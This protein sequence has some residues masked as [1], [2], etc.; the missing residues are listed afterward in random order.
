MRLYSIKLI[1]FLLN[2]FAQ[3]FTPAQEISLQKIY[4][5]EKSD[6]NFKTDFLETDFIFS[7]GRPISL[8]VE[9]EWAVKAF[10]DPMW[11]HPRLQLPAACVFP[12]RKKVIEKIINRQLPSPACPDL[13]F[14]RQKLETTHV[15]VL[16]AGAYAQNPASVFGHSL[17]RLSNR[18][19]PKR[20]SPL[21]SYVVG[22]LA[23][24]GDDGSLARIRK[25]LLGDYPGHYLLDPFYIK[26][27]I[28]NNAESRDL[29]ESD[30]DLNPEEIDLLIDHLW[31]ISHFSKSYYFIGRNCSYQLLK[32]LEAIRPQLSLLSR[33]KIETLPHDSIRW[34]Q[35]SGLAKQETRYY[36]SLRKKINEKI[37]SLSNVN[38]KLLVDATQN[39]I[40]LDKISDTKTLEV[41]NDFWLLRNYQEKMKLTSK[42]HQLM[43]KSLIKRSQL[44]ENSSESDVFLFRES[45]PSP[46]YQGHKTHSILI[47]VNSQEMYEFS[48]F[49][50][51][52]GFEQ[53]GEGFDDFSS[54]QYLGVQTY[55][56]SYGT[57]KSETS[58]VITRI[59]SFENYSLLDNK[60]S[61]L[62]NAQIQD[63][64]PLL[65]SRSSRIV[66]D[67]GWGLSN[68]FKQL[69]P[70][71][72]AVFNSEISL[73]G[74]DKSLLRPG[75][76]AGFK[77]S[78]SKQR[79]IFET[80]AV[81]HQEKIQT[82]ESLTWGWN[83][84]LD[85]S[86]YLKFTNRNYRHEPRFSLSFESCF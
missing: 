47:G 71:L 52:H 73:I 68:D 25:G 45:G 51:A 60:K 19:N 81:E 76:L 79:L 72:L 56:P 11:K 8:T 42:E 33:K 35:E 37:D 74:H 28:Y 5:F 50:G 80:L 20:S 18:S 4:H 17:I 48:F 2:S 41:I 40:I 84:N 3:A 49:Y 16:F 31:E 32:A 82:F 61:W 53:N 6:A 54:I 63:T 77:W 64:S 43:E 83:L 62:I 26:L 55:Q 15:S 75:A 69:R 12:A 10:E 36:P 46:A 70:Y 65:K 39:P 29:W 59:R 38:K 21:L 57:K 86:L 7:P 85:Q 22:F 67:A 30:L 27:G 58:F 34:M 1:Y 14:W 44:G 24:T 78:T 13:E 66:T 9:L 23:N